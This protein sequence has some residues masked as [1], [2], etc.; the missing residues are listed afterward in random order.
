MIDITTIIEAVITL[1]VALITTFLIPYLRKK[2]DAETLAT[3]RLWVKVGVKAAEQLFDGEGRGEEKLEYVMNFIESK[4]F[5]IDT[6]SLRAMVEAEVL[7][8]E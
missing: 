8:L 6:D 1:I 4:G 2:Y 7:E 5:T 3:I